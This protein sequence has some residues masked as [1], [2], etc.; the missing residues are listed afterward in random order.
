MLKLYIFKTEGNDESL[1]QKAFLAASSDKWV[2][3]QLTSCLV[4][5][6]LLSITSANLSY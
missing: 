2:P 4:P 5:G 6:N 3:S 1:V